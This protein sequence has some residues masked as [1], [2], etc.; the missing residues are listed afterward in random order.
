MFC[1]KEKNFVLTLPLLGFFDVPDT[2][3]GGE[4]FSRP[5]SIKW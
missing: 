1:Q 4:G 2:G 5:T 3:E